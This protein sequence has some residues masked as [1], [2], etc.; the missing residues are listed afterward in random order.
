MSET[1]AKYANEQ[2]WG[3]VDT[4]VAIAGETSKTPAAIAL[5]WLLARPGVTAPII[6]ARNMTQLEDNL[7]AT[8][9]QL[10]NAQTKRLNDISA[11]RLPYPYDHL[12]RA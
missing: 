6:G 8:G 2:T 1:W 7:G 5:N 11:R 9:W 4:L 12:V 10:D 3:V